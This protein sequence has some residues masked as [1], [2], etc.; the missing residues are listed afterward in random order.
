MKKPTSI[1]NLKIIQHLFKD[2]ELTSMLRARDK[3]EKAAGIELSCKF[4]RRDEDNLSKSIYLVQFIYKTKDN[5]REDSDDL[6]VTVEVTD[7]RPIN[8]KIADIKPF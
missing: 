2:E 8:F 6:R 5:Y 3:H 1:L 7:S 4:M